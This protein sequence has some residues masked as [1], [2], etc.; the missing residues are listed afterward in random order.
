MLIYRSCIFN[1]FNPEMIDRLKSKGKTGYTLYIKVYKTFFCHITSPHSTQHTLLKYPS[2]FTHYIHSSLCCVGL[3][4]SASPGLVWSI[5]VEKSSLL[6]ISLLI[7][8][9]HLSDLSSLAHSL[10]LCSF[11]CSL[12]MLIDAEI[13]GEWGSANC[14][15][16]EVATEQQ[17]QQQPTAI[18]TSWH[19][20][21]FLYG[22]LRPNV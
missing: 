6:F 22:I 7:P 20:T 3:A 11:S 14:K 16:W 10:I 5:I 4:V 8:P 19:L 2:D 15:C 21:P 18:T 12:L 17:Q 13:R 9:S 1:A